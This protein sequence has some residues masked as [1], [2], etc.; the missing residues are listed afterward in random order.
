MRQRETRPNR[1]WVAAAALAAACQPQPGIHQPPESLPAPATWQLVWA[2][3]FD[4]EALDQESWNVQVVADPHNQEL[5]YYP[6]RV[7]DEPGSNIWLEDGSLVIEAR[8]EDYEHRRYTSGRI[9]TRDRHEFLYG[10]FEARIRQPGETG[11]WPAFWLLGSNI[12]DVGW[13]ACGEI[14]IMEGKGRLADWTSGA[15]HA[16]PN[17]DGN[18]IRSFEHELSEGSFHDSWHLFA[19][20]WE[21]EEIRWYVD[22]SHVH[23]IR[24]PAS[25]DPVYWPFD[26]GHPFFIILN[27]AVGGW[28][29]QGHPPPDDMT[30]QRLYVDFVRVYQQHSSTSR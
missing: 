30:P 11:M 21:P 3:E 2:D 16:G 18:L 20:E 27:L 25:E 26:H 12:G 9:N 19:V 15:L 5:Q 7:D 6:G 13:P 22:E 10:R 24:K 23:T 4:G 1:L 28:F 8:R 17:P 14:D 29:D